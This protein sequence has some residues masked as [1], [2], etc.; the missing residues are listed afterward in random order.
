MDTSTTRRPSY[1]TLN[2]YVE[3]V[4]QSHEVLLVVGLVSMGPYELRLVDSVG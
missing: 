4:G 3:V 1:T 2:I